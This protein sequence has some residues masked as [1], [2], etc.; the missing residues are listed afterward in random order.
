M[1]DHLLELG[2]SLR[3]CVPERKLVLPLQQPSTVNNFETDPFIDLALADQD[4]LS[5][6]IV[7]EILLS[8]PPAG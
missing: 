8:L 5:G 6:Q 4:K 1:W 2:R 7:P 3:G